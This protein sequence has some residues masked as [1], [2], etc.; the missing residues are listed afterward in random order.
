MIQETPIA[1]KIYKVKLRSG[2][3]WIFK[4]AYC[5]YHLTAHQNAY[6]LHDGGDSYFTNRISIDRGC[7]VGNNMDIIK[8]IPANENEIAIFKRK[9]GIL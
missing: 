4:S 3:T 2:R 1:G 7:H 5:G 6:C 8:L 9:F